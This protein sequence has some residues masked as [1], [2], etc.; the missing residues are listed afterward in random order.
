MFEGPAAGIGYI[1][2][3]RRMGK[4]SRMSVTELLLPLH[5]FDDKSHMLRVACR[6]EG[7]QVRPRRLLL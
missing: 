6:R 4:A 2:W 7:P 1:A 3:W 5:R